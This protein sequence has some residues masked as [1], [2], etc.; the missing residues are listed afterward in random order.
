[1][2]TEGCRATDRQRGTQIEAAL[3]SE[4]SCIEPKAAD[5]I[6]IKHHKQLQYHPHTF[7]RVLTLE[8]LQDKRSPTDD[9]THRLLGSCPSSRLSKT[10]L[11]PYLPLWSYSTCGPQAKCGPQ[12]GAGW[13]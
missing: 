13:P 9:L 11:F 10:I 7:A 12:Q 8:I 2:N 1:M 3:M 6:E 4:H 5:F